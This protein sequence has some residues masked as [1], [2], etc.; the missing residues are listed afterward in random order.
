MKKKKDLWRIL[1]LYLP[2]LL[3]MI[4][5]LIP[6]LWALSISF[7][8]IPEF[9]SAKIQ[10]LPKSLNWE[11][12][13]GVWQ[14]SGF[15]KYFLNSL[16]ISLGS[17]VIVLF[18]SICNAYALS[19]YVFKGKSQVNSIFLSTQMMPVILYLVPLF[20][21]FKTIHL[22]DN[23]IGLIIFN[24]VL[25]TPFNTILMTN[26]MRGI[27]VE[28]DEAAMIDGAKRFTVLRKI[29]LPILKPGLV[30]VG[31]FAFIGC[32]NEFLVA[33]TLIQTQTKFTIPVGL[34][35][36]IGEYSV[37]YPS[38][39]AGSIIA[40]IPPV[41]LFALIQKNLVSGLGAGAVKG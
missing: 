21:V 31:S 36:M 19:R 17:V 12:Y 15:S 5:V 29:L 3:I 27:S 32:W 7:K 28:L 40:L 20:A 30:A 4:V 11:N 35:S 33:F 18:L 39:A 14:S 6:F 37:N 2:L 16:L 25:Q 26:F 41:V 22:I 1:Y 24:V 9:Q 13:L 38:L 8:T 34:K 23:P 10:Y